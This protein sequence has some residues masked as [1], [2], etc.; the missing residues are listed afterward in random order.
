MTILFMWKDDAACK[1]MDTDLFFPRNE[2]SKHQE[3]RDACEV[4][5]VLQQCLSYA[6]RGGLTGIWAGMGT[7]ER[8][9]YAADHNIPFGTRKEAAA[10]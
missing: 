7:R 1:G 6:I 9:R 5:V 2:R 4:C 10:A 3:V 8:M